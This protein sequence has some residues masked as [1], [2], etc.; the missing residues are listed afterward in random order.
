MYLEDLEIFNLS[1]LKVKY[2]IFEVGEIKKPAH[3]NAGFLNIPVIKINLNNLYFKL[4]QVSFFLS[5]FIVF[6]L[7]TQPNNH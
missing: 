1:L 3:K 6:S 4:L 7:H 2:K 5:F